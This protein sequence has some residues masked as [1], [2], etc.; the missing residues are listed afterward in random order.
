MVPNDKVTGLRL[1]NLFFHY[2]EII[3]RGVSGRATD[4]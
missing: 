3:R 4:N 2:L 1:W